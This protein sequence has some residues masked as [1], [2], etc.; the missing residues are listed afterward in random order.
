MLVTIPLKLLVLEV[1]GYLKVRTSIR[2]FNKFSRLRKHK[3]WD[4]N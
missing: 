4:I 3:L 1:M 2:L